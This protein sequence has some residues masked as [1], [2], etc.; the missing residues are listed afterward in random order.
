MNRGRR[1]P[2]SITTKSP[3][4]GIG[5]DHYRNRA[6]SLLWPFDSGDHQISQFGRHLWGITERSND[7]IVVIEP[8]RSGEKLARMHRYR[9]VAAISGEHT[10][11]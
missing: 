9:G 3:G 5:S 10:I 6:P 8:L 11:A 4:I 1:S 2:S 7:I